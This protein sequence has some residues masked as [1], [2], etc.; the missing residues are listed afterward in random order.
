MLVGALSRKF[1]VGRHFVAGRR[2][3]IL[4]AQVSFLFSLR[5][6]AVKCVLSKDRLRTGPSHPSGGELTFRGFLVKRNA[7]T[8][9]PLNICWALPFRNE[10]Q[11]ALSFASPTTNSNPVRKQKLTSSRA[12]SN[13]LT[14]PTLAILLWEYDRSSSA[15]MATQRPARTRRCALRRVTGMARSTIARRWM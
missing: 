15:F 8:S 13:S 12:N 11:C 7:G 2:R 4:H 14:P 9:I 1:Y 10:S 6:A 3:R 5:M